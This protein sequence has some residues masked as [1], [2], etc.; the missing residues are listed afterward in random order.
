MFN[1]LAILGLPQGSEWILIAIVALLIFGPQL[2]QVAR[3]LGKSLAGLK[4]G[5]KEAESEFHKGMSE[6]DK[7]DEKSPP[8][9]QDPP[10]S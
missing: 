1:T 5:F 9:K 10:Y 2:P 8:E 3:R 6:S 4:K 7:T